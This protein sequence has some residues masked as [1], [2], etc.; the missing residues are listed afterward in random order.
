MS[1]AD[2]LKDKLEKQLNALNE[3][4]EAGEEKAEEIKGRIAS[5]FD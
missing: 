3:R 5:F 1:I 4:L 2:L